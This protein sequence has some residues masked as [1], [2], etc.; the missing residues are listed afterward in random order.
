MTELN[1]LA[2]LSPLD[3]LRV[4]LKQAVELLVGR[5]RQTLK[6]PPWISADALLISKGIIRMASPDFQ[7]FPNTENPSVA[8]SNV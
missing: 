5:H 4:L 8:W 3:Q 7:I 1:R 6:N 2:G